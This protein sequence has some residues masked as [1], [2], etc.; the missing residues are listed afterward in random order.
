MAEYSRALK[1]IIDYGSGGD[2][3][4]PMYISSTTIKNLSKEMVPESAKWHMR[5]I[6]YQKTMRQYKEQQVI[7]EHQTGV[8]DQKSMIHR[9]EQQVIDGSKMKSSNQQST[10]PNRERHQNGG[11]Q[12]GQGSEEGL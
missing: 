9:T 6:P 11:D 1:R 2:H 3:K 5:H 7:T 4:R 10:I 12:D 8:S